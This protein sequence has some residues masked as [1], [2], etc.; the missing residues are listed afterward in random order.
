MT[1]NGARHGILGTLWTVYAVLMVAV[2]VWIFVY[3]R[4]LTLMWGAI[5]NHVANP[6]TWMTLFHFFL[7]TTVLM[8]LL[9]AIFSFLAAFALLEGTAT[10]HKCGL[11]AA[12]FG[13]LG[14][15]P[16]VALGV[17]TALALFPLRSKERIR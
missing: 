9:S 7:V 15:P 17:F 8:A 2:A 5:I 1:I 14:P 4:T 11:T 13:M 3:N 6:M 12:A 16:G 10:A